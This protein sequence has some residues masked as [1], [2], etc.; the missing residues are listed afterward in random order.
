MATVR[1]LQKRYEK[2]GWKFTFVHSSATSHLKKAPVIA[3]KGS[4]TVKGTS[5]TDVFKKL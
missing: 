2:N 5:L 4:R 3:T 1:E